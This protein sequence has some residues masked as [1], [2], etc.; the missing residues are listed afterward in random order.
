MASYQTVLCGGH[1]A[2]GLGLAQLLGPV[3][4]CYTPRIGAV[5]DWCTKFSRLAVDLEVVDD[6]VVDRRLV[7]RPTSSLHRAASGRPGRAGPSRRLGSK[8]LLIKRR[9]TPSVWSLW[10][11]LFCS[12]SKILVHPE[13][14]VLSRSRALGV[15]E[16]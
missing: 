3:R 7:P 1:M 11:N 10:P 15:R 9:E 12:D 14:V 5:E 6:L 13:V 2:A 8:N 16:A 4:V